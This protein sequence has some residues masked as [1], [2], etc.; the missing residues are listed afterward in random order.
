M[1]LDDVAHLAG[2]GGFTYAHATQ[3]LEL[4]DTLV[5]TFRLPARP[6]IRVALR[7]FRRDVR[8]HLLM[9]IR[10]AMGGTR[11]RI[12]I[13]AELNDSPRCFQIDISLTR[14]SCKGDDIL[15]GCLVDVTDSHA[16]EQQLTAT[17]EQAR[18]DAGTAGRLLSALSH[19]VRTPLGSI[20]GLARIGEKESAGRSIQ[21]L[22]NRIEKS[23]K[24]LLDV[25]DKILDYSALKADRVTLE[26]TAVRTAEL[27]DRAID[28]VAERARIKHLP[29][30]IDEAPGLPESFIGDALRITQVLV[31]L[32]GNAIKFTDHGHIVLRARAADNQLVFEIEDT[33]IGMAPVQIER[34][35]HPFAQADSTTARRYGGSGLGL[36]ISRHLSET[37]HGRIDVTSAPGRGSCFRFTLPLRQPQWSDNTP[38]MPGIVIRLAGLVPLEAEHLRTQLQHHGVAVEITSAE[39][40]C[41]MP[42]PTCLVLPHHKL[43]DHLSIPAGA[44]VKVLGVLSPGE[45]PPERADTRVFAWLETPVRAR[46]LM[47][48]AASAATPRTRPRI[49]ELRV[50]VADDCS[51]NRMIVEDILMRAG[52]QTVTLFESGSD[53]I[54]EV[55]THE[56]NYY[57]AVILDLQMPGMDGIETATQLRNIVPHL[58]V[59]ALSGE[60]DP[61][62]RARALDV[63]M[64]AFLTKPVSDR[65]LIAAI[66]GEGDGNGHAVLPSTLEPLR[67]GESR[68]FDLARMKRRFKGH[69]TLIDK[70]LTTFI[71]RHRDTGALLQLAVS[72][73]DWAQIG[74]IAHTLK[75]MAGHLQAIELYGAAQKV[76]TAIRHQG[77]AAHHY[78]DDM[79]AAL[80][81]LMRVLEM[82]AA[83]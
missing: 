7:V 56:P 3:T 47:T 67:V 1:N 55:V 82:L 70:L 14:T 58:P 6:G 30:R 63:G 36:A 52:V 35:F 41:V 50:L 57:A 19:E 72:Q 2:I 80:N 59:I 33:G 42:L 40:A 21:A 32:L 13:C 71:I 27:I 75:G 26:H 11:Q 83:A 34:L 5:R 73:D 79:L 46:H 29:L 10:E 23:G 37:M 81:R 22:F 68:I 45:L 44:S 20:L 12:R 62:V 65:A 28:L 76:S 78:I 25:V 74:R 9:A 53:A 48:L 8:H 4:S 17:L 15:L 66:M 64:V 24:Y 18:E 49:D 43:D 51:L 69:D 16:R 60:S 77:L 31:N 38:R 61:V 39:D 54:C